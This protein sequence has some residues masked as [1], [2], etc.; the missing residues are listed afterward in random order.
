ME[1]SIIIPVYNVEPYLHRCLDSVVNQTHRDLEIILVDDGSPDNCGAICD[2][3]AQRDPRIV[4]IH[5]ENGGVSSA[6]NAGLERATGEWIGW[7]DPDDWIETDMYEYMLENAR[8][9]DAD[10]VVCGHYKVYEDRLE[11]SGWHEVQLLDNEQGMKVLLENDTL[12]SYCCD[13]LWRRELW[14]GLVFPTGHTFEDMR[15]VPRVFRRAHRTVCLP[16]FKYFYYRH[17]ESIVADQSLQN[18]L[19]NY[20]AVRSRYEEWSEAYPQQK[21]ALIDQCVDSA[22]GIWCAADCASKKVWNGYLPEIREASAFCWEHVKYYQSR[23]PQ[24]LAGRMQ[25]RLVRYPKWWAF[26]LAR[27]VST[28][29]E[30]K[31]GRPL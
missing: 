2:E 28:L 31:H 22:I 24:G 4:V 7:V 26:A 9:Y 12:Q 23:K 29:Y 17:S 10:I 8:R 5:K 30:W 20:T 1:L 11:P 21:D 6:R 27:L 14:K 13:K 25:L 18:R 15:V 3:Y 19:E 16:E